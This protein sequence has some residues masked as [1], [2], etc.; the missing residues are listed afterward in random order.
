MSDIKE[1]TGK[2]LYHIVKETLVPGCSRY[3]LQRNSPYSAEIDK[4]ILFEK[5]YA[6]TE[7]RKIFRHFRRN[8]SD[9]QLLS[10]RERH[11]SNIIRMYHLQG[12]FFILFIGICFSITVFI[13]E[14]LMGK[15]KKQ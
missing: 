7:A 9:S 6:L 5:Q 14:L 11:G 4:V 12:V 1:Q 13:L 2:N 10:N 3:L 15:L 8:N